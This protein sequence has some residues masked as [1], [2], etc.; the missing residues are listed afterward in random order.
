V[1]A[2][3]EKKSDRKMAIKIVLSKEHGGT[4]RIEAASLNE[5]RLL[6]SLDHP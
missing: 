2:A 3:T 5:F 1:V 6:E 4:E